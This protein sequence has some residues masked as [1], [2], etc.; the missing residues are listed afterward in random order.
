[1]RQ[2]RIFILLMFCSCSLLAQSVN[3]EFGKNRVQFT[4]DFKIWD[5]YETENFVTYWY[6]KGQKLAKTVIQYAELNHNDIQDVMEHRM[7]DKIQ[8][9]VYLD[10]TDF[11]Q[12]NIGNEEI[13]GSTTGKTKIVGNK[14]FVY[15]D[16]DHSHLRT[17]IREG[18]AR[19]YLNAILFG[20][21]IQ[22]IVQNAVLLKLPKWY[23][24]GV[25]KYAASTWDYEV[26]DELRDLLY[27]DEDNYDFQHLADYHPEIA[28][29]SMWYYIDQNYGRISISNLLYLTRISSNLNN[30]FEYVLNRDY[31]DLTKDWTKFWKDHYNVES[32]LYAASS[33]RDEVDLKNKLYVPISHM[34]YSPDGSQLLYAYNDLG[35]L[36][37]M[38]RDV[39]TGEE[40]TIMKYGHRNALQQ[41]DYNYPLLAWHPS[42]NEVS[43]LYE[44]RDKRYMRKYDLESNNLYVEQLLP[45]SIQRVYSI[46]YINDLEYIFTGSMVGYSDIIH[47]DS[48]LR[49][50]RL[51]TEDMHDDLNAQFTTW[52][53]IDGVI[54]TSNRPID[55]QSEVDT[56]TIVPTGDLDL[57]FIDLMTE[58]ISLILDTETDIL[59]HKVLDQDRISYLSAETGMAN[60]YIY[61]RAQGNAKS[62]T[63]LNRNIIRH[64]MQPNGQDAVLTYY[65]D[66]AYRIYDLDLGEV[67][68]TSPDVTP[69]YQYLKELAEEPETAPL[70]MLNAQDDLI[71]PGYLFQSEYDDPED[72]API[73]PIEKTNVF[74]LYNDIN[75]DIDSKSLTEWNTAR[76]VA[77]RKTF[78]VDNFLTK[79]DNSVLFEGLENYNNP[80]QGIDLAA[81][82]VVE[83]VNNLQYA[84]NGILLQATIKDLFEDD[85]LVG[86]VRIPTTFNGSEFFLIYENRKKLIDKKYSLY[87]RSY[88]DIYDGAANIYKTKTQLLLGELQ[89]KYPFDIFRSVR[90][91]TSLRNDRYLL[92]SSDEISLDDP[93]K[94]SNRLGV[95]LEYVYDNTIDIST[96]I[97]NG[98]RYKAYVEALNRFDLQVIDGFEFK[99][100]EGFTTVMGYDFRHYI[101]LLRHSV[102]ALRS[103]GA[104]TF[105][106][107]KILYYLGGIEGWIFQSFDEATPVPTDTNFA[108]R[109]AANQLRGFKSNIRN[110]TSFA[111]AN[112][113]LRIPIFKYLLGPNKGSNFF[114]NFQF[115]G[116]YDIGTAWHGAS[117]WSDDNPLNTVSINNSQVISLNVKYFR[118]PL[119][120]GYGAGVRTTLLGYL[121]K[122]DYAWGLDNGELLNPR[123]YFSIGADF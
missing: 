44:H 90:L 56:D 102:I 29:H 64:A 87:R 85:V 37:V 1:M 30:S 104:T 49:E 70:M 84:P 28:G 19:V 34:E 59:D 41:T 101:P 13:F 116:F 50:P 68:A 62:Y 74:N 32:D 80:G 123:F 98:T 25:I 106:S 11:K 94:S 78:R 95:K 27:Q 5:K 45:E 114:R 69:Y 26:D 55:W 72:L 48:K 3:T 65:I 21:S 31:D 97:K 82:G 18:I 117:P 81:L 9:I 24:E 103:A 88:S 118:N 61:S 36:R 46:S 100:S 122:F 57:Y 66:G 42:G 23:K 71:Q 99:P 115:T 15:F 35:K 111:L 43:V 108:F 113:E 83:P 121:L 86:G 73:E 105:G 14:M 112:V 22:E 20:S 92:Q 63:N 67:T 75:K 33:K 47:Y 119:V 96:N 89:L 107:E 40:N 16:G 110:G 93:I 4:D 109:T 52:N 6:G 17:Q 91:K 53:G 10:V 76:I 2:I 54:F 12:S 60:L 120:M 58:D 51:I 38:L 8:I 79:L 39:K 77:G 7:N